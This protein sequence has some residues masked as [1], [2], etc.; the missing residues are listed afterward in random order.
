LAKIEKVFQFIERDY[1][2]HYCSLSGYGE[3]I[4]TITL[5]PKSNICFCLIK[6]EIRIIHAKSYE[7]V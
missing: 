5:A 3:R 6:K 2:E 7:N 1:A 4:V